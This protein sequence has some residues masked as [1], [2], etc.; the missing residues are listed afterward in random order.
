MPDPAPSVPP[1]PDGLADR[2]RELPDE[3]ERIDAN[4]VLSDDAHRGYR[5][6][7]GDVRRYVD[8][9]L[10]DPAVAAALASPPAAPSGEPGRERCPYCCASDDGRRI[11]ITDDGTFGHHLSGAGGRCSGIGRSV[12]ALRDAIDTL[13]VNPD[14]PYRRAPAPSGETAEVQDPAVSAAVDAWHAACHA[15]QTVLDGMRAVVAAV[16]AADRGSGETA[17]PAKALLAT[18]PRNAHAHGLAQDVPGSPYSAEVHAAELASE[19]ASAG[20]LSSPARTSEAAVAVAAFLAA[21][22]EPGDGYYATVERPGES[23]LYSR[24]DDLRAL[25]S[26]PA[27]TGWTEH[28]QYA[29]WAFG[30][31]AV[32]CE[33]SGVRWHSSDRSDCPGPHTPLRPPW[34]SPAQTPEPEAR[35]LLHKHRHGGAPC[36]W[37][38]GFEWCYDWKQARSA[39]ALADAG[40]LAA[41]PAQTDGEREWAIEYVWRDGSTSVWRTKDRATAEEMLADHRAGRNSEHCPLY[42]RGAITASV[43]WRL[44]HV[45]P[46]PWSPVSSPET[47]TPE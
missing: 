43:V 17:E 24:A 47:E 29:V 10:A 33:R 11:P 44:P 34:S 27:Q 9:V 6:A 26:S 39:A 7:I 40:L 45:E 3:L 31:R 25:L 12:A 23:P 41:S 15:E 5:F 21:A 32:R 42:T 37:R 8:G 30:H 16:R 22:P 4:S 18:A 14:A 38:H 2:L 28:E 1:V 13:P 20:L 19:L 35:H 36:P 46:G